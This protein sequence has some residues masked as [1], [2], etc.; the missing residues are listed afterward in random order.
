MCGLTLQE[1][2]EREWFWSP[3][4]FVN[5]DLV[6]TVGLT[7]WVPPAPF[8]VINALFHGY[9]HWGAVGDGLQTT[10]AL[11]FLYIIRCSLHG[12]ALKKNIPNFFKARKGASAFLQ[13][14]FSSSQQSED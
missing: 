9:I 11:A 8:G 1:A 14:P 4:A 10:F 12:T 3:E 6:P 5:E 13:G 2:R 7:D